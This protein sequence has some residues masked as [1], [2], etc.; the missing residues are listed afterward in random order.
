MVLFDGVTV[1][2]GAGPEVLR[3]ISF[4]L[5][6]GSFHF[7]VGASGAG[8][9]SLLKLMYLAMR[10]AAGR[11]ELFGRDVSVLKR[12]DYPAMRRR[13]GVVFQDF[14]LIEH[15]SATDNVALPLRIAGVRETDIKRHV[16]ELLAWVGLK[17]HLD[18]L[19]ATLSG[20]QQQRVAIARAVISRPSLLLADEPT[21]NVDDGIGVRL[22]YLF[23]ELNKMGTT[24]VVATHNEGLVGRF[25]HRQLRI[26]GSTLTLTDPTA[27]DPMATDP[28]AGE[29]APQEDAAQDSTQPQAGMGYGQ[30]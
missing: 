24:V 15:L 5:A 3:G 16:P 28:A 17:D 2:Y 19:P 20:G 4:T 9:S 30:A 8:K 21:G 23:E 10:P 11:V 18:A 1:R 12:S 22:M 6:P 13:V 25:T 14:R 29:A 26:V 27:T 7:L